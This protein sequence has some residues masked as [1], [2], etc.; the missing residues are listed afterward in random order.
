MEEAGLENVTVVEGSVDGANLPEACCDAIYMRRVYHHFTAPQ[1][2]NASLQRAVRPGGRLAVIDFTA[3]DAIFFVRW[4]MG[5]PE[6]VPENRG[7][8]G[9]PVRIVSEE[10]AEAGF[11]QERAIADWAGAPVSPHFCVLSRR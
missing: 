11:E 2:M 9:V 4:F 6:G 1:E 5:L 7:G 8:H 3:E 10:L